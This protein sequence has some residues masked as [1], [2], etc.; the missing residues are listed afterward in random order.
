[1][2]IARFLR[3]EF[4]CPRNVRQHVTPLMVIEIESFKSLTAKPK[5]QIGN[6][7]TLTPIDSSIDTKP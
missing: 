1:M 6:Q 2:F 7:Q 5:T 4:S 3:F